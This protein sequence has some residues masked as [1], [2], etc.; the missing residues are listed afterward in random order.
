MY[1]SHKFWSKLS[2]AKN[3]SL[4]P[5]HLSSIETA[6]S[7]RCAKNSFF[8]FEKFIRQ[9]RK[10]K[11]YPN[12][13]F[14]INFLK[15]VGDIKIYIHFNK[16]LDLTSFSNATKTDLVWYVNQIASYVL[17]FFY[18]VIYFEILSIILVGKMLFFYFRYKIALC[19]LFK[20][21][22]NHML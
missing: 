11:T 19:N 12:D 4:K 17:R 3:S 2:A 21:E 14:S 1:S 5:N 10:S 15:S 18:F 16:A 13:I 8:I 9:D 7:R 6:R 20:T 22:T